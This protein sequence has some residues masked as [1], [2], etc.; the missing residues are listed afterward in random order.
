MTI[1]T[2][3]DIIEKVRQLA[4]LGN[5][6]QDSN[7]KIVDYINSYYLY[8]FPED[9]RILR[10]KDVYSFNTVEGVDVYPFNYDG[11]STIKTPIYCAKR[12]ISL[13]QNIRDFT[14]Y[15]FEEQ[16]IEALDIADGTI[17]P[18]AGTT[19]KSPMIRSSNNNPLVDTQTAPTGIFPAGFPATFTDGN[20]SRV[21]NILISANTATET[22]VVTDDG[23]GNLIGDV[24]AGGTIDYNTGVVANLTFSAVV[25]SGNDINIQY[26]PVTFGRPSRVL[27]SQ[28]QF[29]VRPVP[30]QAYTIEMEGYRTPSM[31]L[32]GTTDPNAPDL[33]NGRPEDFDWWELIA[34]GVAKKFYQDR[35]DVDGVQM[36][37]AFLQEAINGAETKTYAQLG[38]RQASTIYRDEAKQDVWGGYI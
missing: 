10:L 29:T 21:Q 12:E 11:W 24:A 5:G 31:A 20:I 28:Y 22:L 15:S 9:L 30:D 8:D 6:D 37:D 4:A 16:Y 25:P 35:L 33:V 1:G 13:F 32:M 26:I 36:M 18:Y 34:F 7:S 3:Q 17:G 19:T 14:N 2:L 27:F 23:A 38:T